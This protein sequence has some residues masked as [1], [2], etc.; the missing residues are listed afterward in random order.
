MDDALIKTL[1]A[2]VETAKD[3]ARGT[4]LPTRSSFRKVGSSAAPS[5]ETEDLD[6]LYDML[7]RAH[8][9]GEGPSIAYLGPEGT[10]SHQAALDLTDG[11]GR[12]VACATFRSVAES[13][14]RG[15]ADLG[16]LPIENSIEGVVG[17]SLDMVFS[18]CLEIYAELVLRVELDLIGAAKSLTDIVA[19]AS[20]PQ[21]LRQCEEWLATHLPGVAVLP[22]ESTAKAAE[23]VQ[24]RPD[25]AAVVG[26]LVSRRKPELL[27]AEA[28]EDRADN[29]T[30]FW[31]VG[32]Q[33]LED[34]GSVVGTRVKT[35]VAFIVSHAPGSLARA[36]LAL[37]DRHVNVDFIVS[38]LV[39]GMPLVYCFYIDFVGDARLADGALALGALADVTEL[40]RVLGT[41]RSTDDWN[42]Q[43]NLPTNLDHLR[44]DAPT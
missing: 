11:T 22:V 41:Y 23:I 20:H 34:P 19:V 38:R 12:G 24:D 25:H 26:R 8:G 6:A 35:S 18:H 39:P 16:V 27:I 15:V 31:L 9:R 44:P 1:A 40:T 14:E 37:S 3:V 7:R 29:R 17:A 28:I 33:G 4:S 13:V 32:R 21:A 42:P 5:L 36:L 2:I 30:R 10:F 43:V